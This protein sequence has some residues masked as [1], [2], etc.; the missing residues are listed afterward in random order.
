MVTRN[1]ANDEQIVP[2]RKHE[3]RR[4]E[5]AHDERPEIADVKE[6][7]EQGGEKFHTLNA[8]T[9]SMR[10]FSGIEELVGNG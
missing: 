1:H 7:V 2:E 8:M 3:K 5:N 6:E 10:A 9:N 4:I